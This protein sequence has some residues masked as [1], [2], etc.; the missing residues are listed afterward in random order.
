MKQINLIMVTGENNN[1]FYNMQEN[2][3]DFNK[4]IKEINDYIFSLLKEKYE[5]IK[6][7]FKGK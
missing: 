4:K 1:K 5:K 3:F 2:S 6:K 7:E